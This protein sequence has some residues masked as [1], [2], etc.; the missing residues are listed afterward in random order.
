VDVNADG[1]CGAILLD[2]RVGIFL[3]EDQGPKRR[4]KIAENFNRLRKV[5]E[6]NTDRQMDKD[7]RQ[8]DG[9]R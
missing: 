9:R 4:R 2:L 1:Q 6:R 7:R 3:E 5:H 8:T